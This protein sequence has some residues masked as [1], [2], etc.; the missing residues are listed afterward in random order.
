MKRV[1]VSGA[2]KRKKMIL[3]GEV[4][5]KMRAITSFSSFPQ[6]SHSPHSHKALVT[7]PDGPSVNRD[8]SLP[9]VTEVHSTASLYT[10]NKSEI[11]AEFVEKE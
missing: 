10:V 2:S 8:T 4:V 1:F 11:C 7:Q 6:Q 9:A 5:K 3:K